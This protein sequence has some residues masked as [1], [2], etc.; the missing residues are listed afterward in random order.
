MA[1]ILSLATTFTYDNGPAILP[2]H[3]SSTIARVISHFTVGPRLY[4]PHSSS[5]TLG[6]TEEEE[7][8]ISS[9]QHRTKILQSTFT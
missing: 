7:K 5:R 9:Q 8:K 2:L 6:E 4:M 1:S 3:A